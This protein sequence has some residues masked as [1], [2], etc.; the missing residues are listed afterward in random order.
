MIGDIFRAMP[1]EEKSNTLE[2]YTTPVLFILLALSN[3]IKLY[4][5][6]TE[7]T[8]TNRFLRLFIKSKHD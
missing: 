6:I 3:V 1:N 4:I 2:S 5:L 7:V 8:M